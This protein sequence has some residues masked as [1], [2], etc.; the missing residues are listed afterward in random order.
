MLEST[1]LMYMIT[2][3]LIPLLVLLTI[4][5]SANAQKGFVKQSRLPRSLQKFEIGVSSVGAAGT[6]KSDFAYYDDEDKRWEGYHESPTTSKGGLGVT[7]GTFYRI[8]LIG[9]RAAITADINAAYNYLFWKGIGSGGFFYERTDNVGGVTKQLAVPVG[10]SLK[11]GNDGRLE[12]NHRFC[13]TFGAGV[14]PT[15]NTTHLDDTLEVKKREKHRKWGAQPYV[16]F[17]AGIFAGLCFKLRLMYAFGDIQLTED[18]ES[19]N[20]EKFGVLHFNSRL[21]S[22][23]TTTLVI[24]PFSYDWPD[25]GWW[26]SANTRV[27]WLPL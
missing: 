10:L 19:W 11:F 21:K 13:T 8:A 7:L 18:G 2:R 27:N 14:M 16:K 15:F 9:R 5:Y 12:K 6:Y 22:T 24:M 3:K 23:F 25:N 1:L 17:E 20:K 4:A 26:N